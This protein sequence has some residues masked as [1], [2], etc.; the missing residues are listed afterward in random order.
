[1]PFRNR[2][3]R[4]HPVNTLKHVVDVQ[5]TVAAGTADLINLI[6]PVDNPESTA[7]IQVNIGSQVSSIFLNVQVVNTT[8]ATGLI[9]NVYMFLFGNPGGNIIAGSIPD[10]NAVGNSDFRKMVFHQEMAML[11]DANDSIPITLFK[12]VIRIPRKFRRMGVND[13]I[14]LKIGTP[15][16]G[17]EINAC[18]Q[19][20]YKEVR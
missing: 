19:C 14:T 2:S 16:G 10:V 8:D 18:V 4:L 7:A 6:A 13:I 11:S 9:N 20:I 12:G 5:S 15:T 17:A 3:N 1:M